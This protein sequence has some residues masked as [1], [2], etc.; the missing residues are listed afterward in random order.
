MDP[1]GRLEGMG[2][3][4]WQTGKKT[5]EFFVDI[6]QEWLGFDDE[7][8]GDDPLSVIW[9][10]WK[11]NVLGEEGVVNTLF[12]V[13]TKDPETDEY[14]GGFGGLLFG[15]IPEEVRSPANKIIT[16]TFDA[17]DAIYEYSVDRPVGT[18]L[19]I[20]GNQVIDPTEW[21]R[22]WNITNSRSM[23]QA[24]ALSFT[25]VLDNQKRRRNL[26]RN[27]LV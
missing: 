25:D 24:F 22:A 14:G 27:S 3:A 17:L 8:D 26:R 21:V 5:G 1:V 9:G 12:G 16:P 6:G 13:D 19:T 7:F 11:D 18:F 15:A 2:K 4:L 20:A 23:G 10:S